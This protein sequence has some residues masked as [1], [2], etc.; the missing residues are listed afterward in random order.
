[1][2]VWKQLSNIVQYS[3]FKTS[4][5]SQKEIPKTLYIISMCSD[6]QDW[7]LI[8]VW[9]IYAEIYECV[10]WSSDRN[11]ELDEQNLFISPPFILASGQSIFDDFSLWAN[12][13]QLHKKHQQIVFERYWLP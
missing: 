8:T 12:F 3:D 13:E 11:P 9:Y 7:Y 5:M 2:N 6:I 4:K 1:M 10:P